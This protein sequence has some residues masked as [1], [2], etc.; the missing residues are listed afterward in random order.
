MLNRPLGV[1]HSG[2]IDPS[3]SQY[4]LPCSE[5]DRDL[6]AHCSALWREVRSERA[7]VLLLQPEGAVLGAAGRW[8][9]VLRAVLAA[10]RKQAAAGDDEWARADQLESRLQAMQDKVGRPTSW[11]RKACGLTSAEAPLLL[12]TF[13]PLLVGL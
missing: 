8:R 12:F 3:A 5:F 13:Q 1:G 4:R 11:K 6:E 9:P 7:D 2:I 10:M